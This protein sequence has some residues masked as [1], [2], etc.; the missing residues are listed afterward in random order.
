[1]S[2][3]DEAVDAAYSQRLT[4]LQQARWKQVLDVQ[5]PYRRNLQRVCEGE[6]LEI[7]CGIG[8]NL[9]NLNGRI[10]GVDPDT[11]SIAVAKAAGLNAVTIEEFEQL[12]R[13]TPRI[14]GTLLF[15]HVL[16]HVTDDEC[17]SLFAQ[18]LPWLTPRGRVVIECPQE[19]GYRSDAT[20]I[21][22][23]DF[24]TIARRLQRNGIT[25]EREYS[26]PFPRV[27][28][29]VFVYNQFVTLGRASA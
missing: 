28:G 16:E 2:Q 8:R 18:Y 3:G 5:R 27:A 23:M 4:S 25:V 20:H 12:Q 17:D 22:W 14:F 19:V 29:K 13:A 9:R 24:P 6:V 26:F 15:S 7:G 21:E 1:M 11:A 10:L